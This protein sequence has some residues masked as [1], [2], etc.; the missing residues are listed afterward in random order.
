MFNMAEFEFVTTFDLSSRGH[1]PRSNTV[2]GEVEPALEGLPTPRQGSFASFVCHLSHLEA[3]LRADSSLVLDGHSKIRKTKHILGRG[4]TFLV[5]QASWVKDSNEPPLDVALKEIIPDGVT[6][7]RPT[8]QVKLYIFLKCQAKVVQS[9]WKDIL[10]EIRALLHGPLRYHP[11]LVRLLGLQWGLSSL[12]ESTYPTLLMECS[13]LGSLKRLQESMDPLPFAT[14]QKLCHDVAR[15]LSALHACGI[16]HGDMKH[17]NVLIYRNHNPQLGLLDV[18]Y[19]AKLAD[20]GGSVMDMG[21]EEFRRLESSTWPFQAPEWSSPLSRDGMKLTDVYS[22]GL[23]I[24]RAFTD[25][26]GYVSLPGAA[27]DSSIEDKE[28][29]DAQKQRDGFTNIAV[30]DL[31]KYSTDHKVPRESLDITVYALLA[32]LRLDPADRS[33]VKAQAALR[34]TK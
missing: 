26:K 29:L 33:L 15:G 31:Y 13:V 24:W 11:N 3:K 14:K 7:S 30:A 18:V 5:R 8:R 4:N 34:G 12:S 32:T 1:V 2:I 6:D 19:T 17:E 9:D 22:F 20:F 23:L 25:G 27:Q 28:S 10:F 21:S 16:V